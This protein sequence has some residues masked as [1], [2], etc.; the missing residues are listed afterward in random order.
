MTPQEFF[1]FKGHGSVIRAAQAMGFHHRHLRNVI[2]KRI[3]AS[4]FFAKCISDYSGGLVSTGEVFQ[5][6]RAAASI[7]KTGGPT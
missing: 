1:R 3:P 6:N 5:S 4:P 2:K 7:G